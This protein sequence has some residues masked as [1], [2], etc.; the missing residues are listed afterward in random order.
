M[1]PKKVEKK[2][3][4]GDS[5]GWLS[6]SQTGVEILKGQV[7]AIIPPEKDFCK[8]E[9]ELAGKGVFLPYWS[10]GTWRK[11]ECY[12]VMIFAPGRVPRLHIPRVEALEKITELTLPEKELKKIE[13]N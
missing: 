7:V 5:V 4:V 13:K 3:A 2:F 11:K 8:V 6:K 1:N 12:A 9:E 10:G